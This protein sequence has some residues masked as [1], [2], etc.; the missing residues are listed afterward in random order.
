MFELFHAAIQPHQLLLSLLLTLVVCYWLL[1][2]LGA[3]DFE[4][5][6]PDDLGT[7]GDAHHG[8]GSTHALGMSTGGAWLSVGRFLGFSQVP[9]MVW[10]SFM[11]LFMW[12]GSLMLNEWYNQPGSFGQAALL[13]LP[14]LLGSLIVTKLVTYPVAKLFKAMGDADSEAE[15][16]IGRT[17]VV[18]STE[19]DASYGQ[20][21][22]TTANVPLLINVRTQPGVA[23]LKRGDSAKVIS[24][25]PDNIFYL[26]EPA[27]QN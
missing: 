2:L 6:L 27:P 24:A 19:A 22:I 8:T 15:E 26:I 17:G 25:G 9:L 5:D 16:V 20:L 14:N 23:P 3:L 10:L 11:I 21:E 4:A 12:F 1:V 13:L 7:D 18:T